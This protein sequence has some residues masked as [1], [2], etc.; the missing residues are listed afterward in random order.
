MIAFETNF[1]RL[2]LVLLSKGQPRFLT[3]TAVTFDSFLFS[4][5]TACKLVKDITVLENTILSSL[6]LSALGQDEWHSLTPW[7]VAFFGDFSLT[8]L[9]FLSNVH[10]LYVWIP[11]LGHSFIHFQ[12][13]SSQRFYP[14][15]QIVTV[16]ADTLIIAIKLEGWDA[17]L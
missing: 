2:L 15:L 13:H 7:I 11:F 5:C 12:S 17:S 14:E 3:T 4:S 9:P 10:I 1:Y 8:L 6:C 16:D